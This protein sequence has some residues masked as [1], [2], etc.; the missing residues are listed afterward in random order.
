MMNSGESM[1]ALERATAYYYVS[2][3]VYRGR[4]D[5]QLFQFSV[6]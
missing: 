3:G 4:V 2:F 1:T 5:N 6:C